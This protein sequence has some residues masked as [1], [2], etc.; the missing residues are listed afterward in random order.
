MIVPLPAHRVFALGA[1]RTTLFFFIATAAFAETDAHTRAILV[2]LVFVIDAASWHLAEIVLFSGNS[3]YNRVWHDTLSTRFFYEKVFDRIRAGER[4]DVLE[5]F[6]E[7]AASAQEDLGKFLDD[8]TVWYQWGGFRK[9]LLGVGSFL[10]MWASYGIFYGVAGIIGSALR[11][12][13]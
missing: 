6:K 9:T 10:W 12:G 11:N 8:T 5:L 4:V 7:G 2:L 13:L 3:V 1:F